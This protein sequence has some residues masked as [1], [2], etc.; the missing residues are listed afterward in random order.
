MG[1]HADCYGLT[2]G[3]WMM[4]AMVVGR[5]GGVSDVSVEGLLPCIEIGST[6][7]QFLERQ[8]LGR[9]CVLP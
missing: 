5:V 1:G 2:L 9:I 4:M 6:M 8:E 7:K 3:L